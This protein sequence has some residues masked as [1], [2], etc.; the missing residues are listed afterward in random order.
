MAI[1]SKQVKFFV[2]DIETITDGELI[3]QIQYP[4]EKLSAKSAIEKYAAERL[5]T[6]G[7]DFIPHTYHVPISIAIAK[8]GA[9]F[10]LLDL[11]TLDEAETRPHQMARDFWTGWDKYRCPTLVT[12]NGRGFDMPVLELAAFRYGIN[13]KKWFLAAGS[14]NDRPRYR[15]NTTGHIDLLELLTNFS[16]CRFQ[17][18][19]NLA[20]TLLGKPGKMD[21]QGS[22]V[23]RTYDQGD[24]AKI[25][26]YCRCDVL[27]TYFVFLR[28]RVMAGAITIDDEQRI[29]AET[30]QWLI[31]KKDSGQGF[32]AYLAQWGDWVNPW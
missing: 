1:P 10:S 8:I 26:S 12:F 27:D 4:G 24:L 22:E 3:R 17:G 6:H 13:I 23:Q 2:F 9:D 32:D 29:V 25:H 28:T 14:L 7:S 21:M 5:E 18:G 19:L 11:V 20:A 30:K 15:F 16:A 31:E